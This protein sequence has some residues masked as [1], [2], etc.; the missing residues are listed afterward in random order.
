MCLLLRTMNSLKQLYTM[1]MVSVC[2]CVVC[3]FVNG[4]VRACVGRYDGMCACVR[5]WV[6]VCVHVCV[7][8]YVLCSFMDMYDMLMLEPGV[9]CCIP[10]LL[11]GILYY[12]YMYMYLV[13]ALQ[14]NFYDVQGTMHFYQLH[15][16]SKIIIKLTYSVSIIH[17]SK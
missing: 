16:I 2:H 17:C 5:R 9:M 12:A 4:W 8:I 14:V 11:C 3:V 10:V 7:Q 1:N 15:I 6:R 13:I